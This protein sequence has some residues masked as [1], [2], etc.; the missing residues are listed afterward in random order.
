MAVIKC[1][2]CGRTTNTAVSDWT[3]KPCLEALECYAAYEEDKGWVKGCAYDKITNGFD[4]QYVD[5]I[6]REELTI[7]NHPNCP[8]CGSFNVEKIQANCL[9]TRTW[10][11]PTCWSQPFCND[12]GYKG[13]ANSEGIYWYG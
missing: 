10:E 7:E 6:I 9:C 13:Y 11:G 5:R 8:E 3:F 1:K 12:C 4:K 2:K